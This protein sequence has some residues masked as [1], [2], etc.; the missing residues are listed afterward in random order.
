MND[1]LFCVFDIEWYARDT[2]KKIRAVFKAKGMSGKPL[3][4]KPPYG[5]KKSELDKNVWEIDEEVAAIVRRIY[6]MCIEGYGP[7]Q[8]AKKLSSENILIPAAY[9][10][11]KGILTGHSYKY[12]TRWD[13]Q[14]VADILE[15]PEYI[16][17]TV[18]F[19]T[20]TKSYKH[21]KRID[22]PKEDWVIFEN[23][24]PAII[25]QHDFDLVQELRK[26]KRVMQ[27]CDEINPFSGMV[28]CADCGKPMYLC[29][30]KSLT[31]EQ[32]HMKC[33]TYSNDQSECSAHYIRT[34]VLK[35]ILIKEINKLLGYVRE[36][37]DKFINKAVEATN[38]SHISEVKAAKKTIAK[39]EKRIAEIDKLFGRL[40]EDNV[41]GRISDERFEM[42][43]TSYEAEQGQL[44]ATVA[45]LSKFIETKEQQ[46]SNINRFVEIVSRYEQLS[47]ITPEQMHELIERIEVHAPDKSSGHRQ[48][49]VEIY[50]RFRVA[51]ASVVLD[52]RDYNKK[53]KA[54]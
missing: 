32:E 4:N 11:S 20:H 42:M 19:K 50:F 29:R 9:A 47:D 28:Y 51:S 31:K 30:S 41:S 34:C 14:T 7:Q 40:Y 37:R 54:A 8:I 35:E 38:E 5:Y 46:T 12:P 25:S 45:E 1:C 53:K 15:K 26:H 43:S 44:K 21:K 22:N 36:N 10:A 17:H 23:T 2:S 48:Q 3:A 52:R 39:S 13:G 18:N 24:H 33:S 49:K 16:G 6:K 27:K